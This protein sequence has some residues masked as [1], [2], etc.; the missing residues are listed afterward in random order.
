MTDPVPDLAVV[1]GSIRDY[2]TIHPSTAV[3]VVEVSDSSLKYDTGDKASLYASAGIADYWVV[4]L[5]GRQLIVFRDPQ[6]DSTGVFGFSYADMKKYGPNQ[7]A[8]PL[9]A[10]HSSVLVSDLLP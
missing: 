5:V 6:M 3:L 10:P 2:G 7:S 9:R 4:D 1:Q 8:S